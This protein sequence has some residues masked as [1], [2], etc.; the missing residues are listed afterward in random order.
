MGNILVMMSAVAL[1]LAGC[2]P[3]SPPQNRE[4]PQGRAETKT[5]E[6]ASAAGYDGKAIRKSLDTTLNRNDGRNREL[7]KEL[8]A[9]GGEQR[10]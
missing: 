9:D 4:K 3:S 10:Q 8:K 2:S 5:L 7:E 6:G 1:L